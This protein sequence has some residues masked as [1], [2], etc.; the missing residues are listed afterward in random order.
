MAEQIR[1]YGLLLPH[2]GSGA[3]PDRIIGSAV[4]AERLGF[5][6]VW[7]R[8]HLIYHPHEYEDQDRTFI[9]PI[10]ILSAIASV[11]KTITLATGSLIPH[12]HPIHTAVLLTSLEY[13]AGPGRVLAGWGLGTYDHEF[14]AMGLGD[15]DRRE[16]LPEYV[17]ILRKLWTGETITHAGK[18][19][20]FDNVDVHPSPGHLIPIWYCGTSVA[21]TRRAVEYCDGWIPG[22]MPRYIF[23]RRIEQMRRMAEQKRRTDLPH[24]GAIPW[25]SPGKT[26][27]EASKMLDLPMLLAATEQRYG[28]PPNGRTGRLEDLDGAVIAGP[29]DV[30]I[31]GVRKYQE[32]GGLHFVFD[33]RARVD[34]WED[35][36]A[37]LGEE[38]LPDL[39]RGDLTS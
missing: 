38:V 39:K 29:A 8:D 16:L 20:T 11:T 31:D 15:W 2:F 27:E 19:Y 14:D 10:V 4:E 23:A 7:V 25:V 36:V 18:F 6:S 35:C 32:V 5:D 1:Q 17:E 12:R 28:E 22:R 33:L 24:A 21:S 34:D 37:F 13:I 3:K 30:I 9:D 26:R